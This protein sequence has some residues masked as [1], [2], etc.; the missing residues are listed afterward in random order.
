MARLAQKAA[1]QTL[2]CVVSTNQNSRTQ[3]AFLVFFLSTS[4]LTGIVMPP[5]LAQDNGIV[6]EL[7]EIVVTAGRNPVV[8]EK[9]G[10][11]ST[12]VTSHELE[13]SQVRYVA[14]ALRRVPGVAVSRSGSVG[15]FTQIRIR[16][17]EA[18]HVLVLIDGVEVAGTSSGEFDFGTL[19]VA[20][21]DRIEVIRGPQSALYGSN[22]AAGVIQII[23]KGGIRN[24]YRVTGRSEVGSDKSVLGN[25]LVQ[26]GGETF[27][28]ALSGAARGTEGFNLSDFGSEKD[29]DRNVTLNG[30]ARWDITDDLFFDGTLRL[31]DR[32]S[33]TDDQDFTWGSPTYGQVIDTPGKVESTDIFGG[34]GLTWELFDDRFVQKFR[35][36]FADLETRGRNSNGQYGD[37]GTRYHLSYQGTYAF[38]TPQFWD[39]A[40]SLT[41]AIEWERETYQNAY[42]SNPSQAAAQ[43]RDLFGTVAEYRGE[44]FD[45]AF[46][47]GA[48][49]YDQ[50]DRFKDTVTYSVSGAYLFPQFG[51]RLHASLG[52][53]STN[54]T[55]FEQF[56]FIPSSFVG[57]PDLKPETN[58]GWDIGIEQRFW[59]DRAMIDVA[60]FNERL[61]DEIQTQFLPSFASTPVNRDGTSKRQGVE[62]SLG[63]EILQNLYA[64]A[65]YTYLD[66]QEPSGA[67]EVRRPPHSGSFGLTYGFHENRGTVFV[68][69]IYN[70]Q[71]EDNR[72][73]PSGS[74]RVTLNDYV[75]VNA[76]ADYQV[77]DHLQLFGRVENLLDQ[78]YEEVYGFNTQGFTAFAGFKATF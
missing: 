60:Y 49:R 45:R 15:G 44:F 26:G 77:T 78:D 42:P 75:M 23:T 39:S 17:S 70:G 27:D 37:D 64:R 30:K 53:G 32:D 5:A 4:S 31:T 9:V 56:G 66:A 13:T 68:D 48:L 11:A 59:Q 6:L 43:E 25:V 24:G 22:A 8:A 57:N 62:I 21:I 52:T 10:R 12:V 35:G 3:S 47:T 61:E 55:F 72:F 18:N 73:T 34:G 19:Q 29:G 20:D 76:G 51:T 16:G 33:D 41:G 71:M 40:H 69:A 7:E 28:I 58:F 38:D 2:G 36:E 63:V 14:D 50:N 65:S 74:Q 1:G 46:V 54:P 67:E